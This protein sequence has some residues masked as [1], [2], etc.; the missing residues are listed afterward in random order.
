MTPSK[1]HRLLTT[2]TNCWS[3]ISFHFARDNGRTNFR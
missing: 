3:V 1:R 2:F